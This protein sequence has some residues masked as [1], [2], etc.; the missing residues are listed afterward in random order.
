MLEPDRP[1]WRSHCLSGISGK[2]SRHQYFLFIWWQ[3]FKD[4]GNHSNIFRSYL[5]MSMSRFSSNLKKGIDLVIKGR[6]FQR[7]NNT[8]FH[9]SLLQKQIFI[10][11][12]ECVGI[13]GIMVCWESF[14]DVN[15]FPLQEKWLQAWP[16]FI[17]NPCPWLSSLISL[18]QEAKALEQGPRICHLSSFSL[19]V[20]SDRRQ[21][22]S[23]PQPQTW[24]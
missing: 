19:T 17:L 7:V 12:T 4:Q 21:W 24:K 3:K 6:Y 15:I 8:H 13:N 1:L 22:F 9:I 11:S 18:F 2:N 20:W 16:I 23:L 5:P 14:F 10:I